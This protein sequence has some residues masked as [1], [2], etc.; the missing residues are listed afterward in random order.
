MGVVSAASVIVVTVAVVCCGGSVR[1]PALSIEQSL[2]IDEAQLGINPERG[3]YEWEEFDAVVDR[4]RANGMQA[5]FSVVFTPSHAV[6]KE[7]SGKGDSS[8]L[9]PDSAALQ[10]P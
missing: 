6:K 8:R 9:P 3:Q 1:Q 4:I 5:L 2:P 10:L 7:Y